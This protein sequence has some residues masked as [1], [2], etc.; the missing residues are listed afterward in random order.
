MHEYAY[1][2]RILQSVLADSAEVAGGAVRVEASV[3]EMLGP[4][5][6]SLTMACGVL[7]KGT[8]SEGSKLRMRV[9]T[10]SV[11]RA[12]CN[13]RGRRPAMMHGHLDDPAFA[14]PERESSS[15]VATGFEGEVKRIKWE[16]H[17]RGAG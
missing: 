8:S 1:A 5:K 14:F 16:E 7:A 10:G 17:P 4:T 12:S 3:G 11:E 9:S 6:K 2:G 13:F 15:G